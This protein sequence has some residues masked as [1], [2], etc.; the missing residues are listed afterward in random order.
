MQERA[1]KARPNV[2]LEQARSLCFTTRLSALAFAFFLLGR[3]ASDA[4][5]SSGP[6]EY[7]LKAALLY[8]FARFAEWPTG[9]FQSDGDAFVIAIVGEDPFGPVLDEAVRGRAIEGRTIKLERWLKPGEVGRCQILFISTS[10][11]S[12]LQQLMS[13]Q[14]GKPVLMVSDAPGFVSEGGTIGLDLEDGRVRMT[15]NMDVV[16]RSGVK[17]SSKLLALSRLIE[18]SP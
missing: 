16:R 8:N 1:G 5:G 12:E 13:T 7:E 2:G 10:D 11:R 3:V 9:T 15:I 18:D 14:G 17:I 4:A 6:A